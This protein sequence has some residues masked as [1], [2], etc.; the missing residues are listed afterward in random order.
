MALPSLCRNIQR[1]CNN[2]Q[3]ISIAQVNNINQKLFPFP[4]FSQRISFQLIFLCSFQ[5]SSEHRV[6][7]KKQEKKIGFE[8]KPD[9]NKIDCDYIGPPDKL[10]NLRPVLRHAPADETP[11]E[12]ELRLK[13]I[14]VEKWNQNFWSNH[15]QN[16][17][18]VCI[19]M[20]LPI[21]ISDD[22]KVICL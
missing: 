7:S 12:K 20:D 10:S 14:E 22:L 2:I 3:K 19:D 21:E 17:V 6:K 11:I 4:F 18:K 5:F 13:R 9:I 8:S 15:N 1:N 16:F